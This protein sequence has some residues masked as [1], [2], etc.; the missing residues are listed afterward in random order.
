MRLL[1][2]CCAIACITSVI[3]VFR[4]IMRPSCTLGIYVDYR[5]S[6]VRRRFLRHPETNATDVETWI[7]RHCTARCEVS[8]TVA[9]RV[10]ERSDE[11]DRRSHSIGAF[12]PLVPRGHRILAVVVEA[13]EALLH[14]WLRVTV[15]IPIT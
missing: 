8:S 3:S 2:L 5:R 7:C 4:P 14:Q 13:T 11:T 1:K 12:S 15:N 10:A 6:N 9:G